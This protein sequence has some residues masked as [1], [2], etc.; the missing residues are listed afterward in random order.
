[1]AELE[2]SIL[3]QIG[4]N[5]ISIALL[6]EL[7]VKTRKL[8]EKA[9]TDPIVV[10]LLFNIAARSDPPKLKQLTN[11]ILAIS[12]LPPPFLEAANAMIASLER[13]GKPIEI[14]FTAIDGRKVDL[15]EMKGKVVFIDFWATW[16]LP[17]IAELPRTKS[18]Y[19]KYNDRGFEI[20]GISLD[21][22]KDKLVDFIKKET[23]SWPQY[24]E[25][26]DQENKFYKEFGYAGIPMTWLIDKAGNLRYMNGSTD[27][28]HKVLELLDE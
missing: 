26:K 28:E 8:L 16:C 17:C 13:I 7:E 24:F 27:L 22:D 11:E 19:E 1:M 15:S 3:E 5:G 20:I 21:K 4:K 25:G 6:E 18:V 12:E 2:K 14:R 10:G 23:I 9:P